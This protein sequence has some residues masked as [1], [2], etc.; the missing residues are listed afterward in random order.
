MSNSSALHEVTPGARE[1]FG[2]TLGVLV[3]NYQNSSAAVMGGFPHGARGYQVLVAVVGGELPNQLALAQHLGIDRTVMTYLIDDFVKAGLVERRLNP[4]DRRAR[5]VVATARGAEVLAELQRSMGQVED[6]V[7]AALEDDE[8]KL[9]RTLLRR[10]ACQ[11]PETPAHGLGAC[12]AV[13][14]MLKQDGA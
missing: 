1:D 10:V 12:E 3:R 6:V 4:A 14:Q 5:L 13:E 7:L 9:F 8:R 11:A 2:W